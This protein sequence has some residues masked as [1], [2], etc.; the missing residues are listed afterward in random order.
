MPRYF[1]NVHPGRSKKDGDDEDGGADMWGGTER[2]IETRAF[3]LFIS[4]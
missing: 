2:I 3:S 1:D 4:I